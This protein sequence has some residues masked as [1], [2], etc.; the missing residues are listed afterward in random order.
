VEYR[1]LHVLGLLGL[2]VLLECSQSLELIVEIPLPPLFM[3]DES[4]EFPLLVILCMFV[5]SLSRGS[6][7]TQHVTERC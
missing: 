3:N 1:K 2:H 5:V 4:H 6:H 7:K